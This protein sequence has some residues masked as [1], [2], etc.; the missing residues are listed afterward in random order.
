MVHMIEVWV[1]RKEKVDEC[2]TRTRRPEGQVMLSATYGIGGRVHGHAGLIVSGSWPPELNPS[3]AGA[4]G[5]PSGPCSTASPNGT[6]S[7][8]PGTRAT[9]LRSWPRPPG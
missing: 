7:S 8:R 2:D 4:S 9:S 1:A 5:A 6:G 3:R